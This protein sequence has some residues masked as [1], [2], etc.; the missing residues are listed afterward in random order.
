MIPVLDVKNG[1]AVHAVAGDRAHYR[2]LQSVLHPTADP[3]AL[4]RAYRDRLDL[5]AIYVADLD[6]IERGEPDLAL[7]RALHDLGLELWID[8]G[9]EDETQ[10][11]PMLDLDRA[12]IV[13]GL[14]T[15]RGHRAV[16]AI[17]DRAGPDRV[18]ASVD[19]FEGRS[20][21]AAGADW[22]AADPERLCTALIAIGVRQLLL[23]DLARVGTG[24]GTGTN[25]LLTRLADR[26]AGLDLRLSVGGGIAGMDDVRSAQR[27]GAAAVLVG[28]ALHD[29]RIDRR[30]LDAL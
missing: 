6:G 1:Q 3:I 29:G 22:A 19:L 2:P 16:Q 5:P 10:L 8:A 4:A 11:G 13:V 15:V 20:R 7:V 23:L 26:H 21:C 28:S 12:T 17:V 24:R 9:L 14:E 18:V 25:K 30:Q 27:S